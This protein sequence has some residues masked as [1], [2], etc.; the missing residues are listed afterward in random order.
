M[1]IMTG[2]KKSRENLYSNEIPV[3]IDENVLM[4]LDSHDM[5]HRAI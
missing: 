3:K 4:L 5:F 2:Y 1:I